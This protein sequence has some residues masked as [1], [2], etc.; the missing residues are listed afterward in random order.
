MPGYRY[1]QGGGQ[2]HSL[3]SVVRK[4]FAPSPIQCLLAVRKRAHRDG[5]AVPNGVNV[6]KLYVL[7]FAAVLGTDMGM[8]ER[9]GV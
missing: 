5:S 8:N 9:A 1:V 6:R 3:Q 2:R 4:R 7:P